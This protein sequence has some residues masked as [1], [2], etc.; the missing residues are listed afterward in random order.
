MKLRRLLLGIS[1]LFLCSGTL[2]SSQERDEQVALVVGFGDG[3]YLVRCV[4]WMEGMT[5]LDLLYASGLQIS[6]DRGLVC[7]IGPEGC[8][9]PKERC[10]CSSS[11]WNYWHWQDGAWRYSG[12]GAGGYL[13][14][15]GDVD[16]WAWGGAGTVPPTIAPDE[17][18]APERVAPGIPRVEVV[19]GDLLACVNFKGDVNGNAR[20]EGHCVRV[21]E[22][23]SQVSCSLDRQES[24]FCGTL[25]PEI[26]QGVYRITFSILDPDGVRGSSEW[27][28]LFTMTS[29]VYIFCPFISNG[30]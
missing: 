30:N 10:I 6:E 14:H 1:L 18:F 9:Y 21:D 5:G 16:G 8:D 22:A 15:P 27:T 2:L 20:I 3:S 26:N 11:Y 25:V 24:R 19:N 29:P 23:G 4:P 7:K 17:I 28:L 12:V 13:L